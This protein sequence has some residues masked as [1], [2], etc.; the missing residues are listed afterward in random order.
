VPHEPFRIRKPRHHGRRLGHGPIGNFNHAGPLQKSLNGQPD[1]KSAPTGPWATRGT[2]RPNNPPPPRETRPRNIAPAFRNKGNEGRRFLDGQSQMF[3]RQPIGLG[4]RR[5]PIFCFHKTALFAQRG[6]HRPP[7]GRE[8]PRVQSRSRWPAPKGH[9]RPGPSCPRPTNRP[10]PIHRPKSRFRWAPPACRC[11][12]FQ[13]LGVW[14]P[15]PRRPPGPTIR[16]TGRTVAV[17]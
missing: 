2:A 1:W 9:V 4:R 14:P 7:N 3:R 5:G 10:E 8:N 16:S 13:T 15:S 17:P 6:S 11:P 12:R